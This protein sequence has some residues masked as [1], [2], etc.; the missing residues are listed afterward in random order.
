MSGRPPSREWI[1]SEPDDDDDTLIAPRVHNSAKSSCALCG[2]LCGSLVGPSFSCG[3]IDMKPPRTK[4]P[5]P[6]QKR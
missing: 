1:E 6:E 2:K 4:P 3:E 5:L